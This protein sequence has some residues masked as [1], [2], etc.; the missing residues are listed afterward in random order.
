MS[1]MELIQYISQHH[2]FII[3]VILD[4]GDRTRIE[5]IGR[6]CRLVKNEWRIKTEKNVLLIY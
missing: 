5:A 4:E 2:E 3:V 1:T 6:L